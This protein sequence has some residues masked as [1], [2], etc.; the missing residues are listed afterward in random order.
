M[1]GDYSRD[2][3]IPINEPVNPVIINAITVVGHHSDERGFSREF[4]L[5]VKLLVR[6]HLTPTVKFVATD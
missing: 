3:L 5:F 4:D 1:L 6:R 2:I